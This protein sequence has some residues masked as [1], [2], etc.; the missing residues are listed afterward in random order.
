MHPLISAGMVLVLVT[1]G[2]T[3]AQFAFGLGL[4]SGPF[5]EAG[6]RALALAASD[7]AVWD[8][9][10]DEGRLH[11]GPEIERALGLEEGAVRARTAPGGSSSSTRQTGRPMAPRSRR[12]SGAGAAA[13]PGVPPAARRWQLSLVCA[14]R[15]RLAGRQRR[16]AAHRHPDRRDRLRR[17]EDR[18]LADAVRD[19]LTGLPNRAL[20]L[21]RLEQAMRRARDSADAGLYVIAIDLDRF[22]SFNDGLGPEAGDY[23]LN[24]V[25]RRLLACIGPEDTLARLPG[26]SSP[27]SGMP[28]C[29]SLASN[30]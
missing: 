2:F 17:S 25:G 3:L 1:M 11:V 14:A 27:S 28:G 16:R 20:F 23:L 12:P 9:Q 8:W 29:R 21:D 19:R 26:T 6:R 18:L 15:P 13:F 10:V 22:K 7:Q 24:T 5:E 30:S 4:A